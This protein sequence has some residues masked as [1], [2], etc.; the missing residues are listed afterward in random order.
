VLSCFFRREE[1]LLPASMTSQG[2]LSGGMR[3]TFEPLLVL[4]VLCVWPY[5]NFQLTTLQ[6][7]VF[8]FVQRCGLRDVPTFVANFMT[9]FGNITVCF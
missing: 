4:F 8:I 3:Q 5:S 7:N 9:P 6:F 2:W 1:E